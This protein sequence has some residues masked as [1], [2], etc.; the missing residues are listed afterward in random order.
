MKWK[1]WDTNL[2]VRLLGE[3]VTNLLFWM[4]FPFMAIYFS[5]SFGKGT[6]GALL[7]ISQ[8]IC[9]AVGLVGGYCAD[10]FGRK[11]M[12]VIAGFGQAL[13]F[14]PFAIG[15]S[16][17]ID[18][19][20]LTFLSFSL[21]G[22]FGTLYWPASHAMIADVVDEKHRSSIFAVFYTS[23]NISVVFGP[24]LGG[25]FFFDYRFAFIVACFVAALILAFVLKFYLRETVPAMKKTEQN[26]NTNWTQYLVRQ[27]DDYRIITKD[28]LFLLFVIAGVLVAQT[29]MQLDL[30]MAV[31]TTDKFPGQTLFSFG[32]WSFHIT[33]KEAFSYIVSE[34]GL[35]VALFTVFMTKWM[36]KYK[37]RNVFVLSSCFYGVGIL[38]F[39][40]TLNIWVMFLAL[41]IFTS[42]E[43][44]VVG[45]QDAFIS[46]LAPENMRGQ[47]FA[48]SSLRFSI[49]R[50]IAPIAIPMT[51]WI[52]F[53]WTFIIL[54]GLAFISAGIY[55]S[56]FT[57]FERR[58]KN[59][60]TKMKVAKEI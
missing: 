15:V 57:M 35:I 46:K 25:I 47:Y 59:A 34:N 40:H 23:V 48:A 58:E 45:I 2:K 60:A 28:K 33:G 37:E 39:G 42:A 5:D 38:L 31:Y 56:M 49:G 8:V 50:T 7:V 18:S 16:P 32:N 24:I 55:N 54:G 52:G 12:M 53:S 43:I 10:H 3:G 44:M 27:L 29:F 26:E 19:P 21:L 11:R 30:L 22:V 1:D 17:W 6:A 9:V 4:F 36:T 20:M 13:S 14:I 51:V 41:A